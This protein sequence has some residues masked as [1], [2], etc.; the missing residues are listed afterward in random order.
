VIGDTDHRRHLNYSDITSLQIGGRGDVVTTTTW[1]S[2]DEDRKQRPH[3]RV[4]KF[5][6]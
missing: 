3:P 6:G 4:S 1:A 5:Q 2:D